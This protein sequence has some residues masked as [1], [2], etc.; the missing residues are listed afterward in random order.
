[1]QCCELLYVFLCIY[2]RRVQASLAEK[3]TD[4]RLELRR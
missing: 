3:T 1:M 2:K 4:Y